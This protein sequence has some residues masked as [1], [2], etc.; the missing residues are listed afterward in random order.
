MNQPFDVFRKD[1]DGFVWR[2]TANSLDE[3]KATAEGFSKIERGFELVI[4]NQETQQHTTVEAA[5]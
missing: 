5:Q 2:S 4:F 3:A 1:K